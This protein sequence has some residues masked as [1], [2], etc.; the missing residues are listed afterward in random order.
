MKRIT[1]SLEETQSFTKEWLQTLT[2][3]KDQ[4][5]VV[6]LYGNLGAGKTALTKCIAKELGISTPVTSPTFVIQKIY[7]TKHIFLKRLI[8]I[9]AYRLNSGRELQDLNF[10]EI[11]DN[12]N[13]IVVIE[14]PENVKEILPVDHIKIYC[15]F[16][17]ENT[18]Q[19]D[20][21]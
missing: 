4:A 16:I 15:E 6:G 10:E 19:F 3:P 5:I 18:R 20:V 2:E 17:D 7:E 1:H 21:Q 13:N 8:H 12:K 9:D 11:V 14:W